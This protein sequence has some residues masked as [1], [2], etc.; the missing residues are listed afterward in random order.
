MKSIYLEHV[1]FKSAPPNFPLREGSSNFSHFSDPSMVSYLFSA[2]HTNLQM[3]ESSFVSPSCDI[4][5][6]AVPGAGQY[7]P[8]G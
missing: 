4:R 6:T 2:P 5:C 3:E 8:A 7:Q 1:A